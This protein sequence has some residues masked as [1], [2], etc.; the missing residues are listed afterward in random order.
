M[1]K[2]F[3]VFIMLFSVLGIAACGGNPSQIEISY[4]EQIAFPTNL[5]IDG[6]T[7]SWDAVE[8]AAGYYVY[9][10]GEEVKEVKTNSYDF[11]SLDGTRI[12]F[13]VVTKAPK[14]MQD[15]AQSASVAYVENK[16]EE[17]TAMQLVLSENL[18]MELDPG[19][20]EELVNKGMLATEFEDMMDA[21]MEFVEDMDDV[22]N[23]NEG[24]AAIDTMMESVENPEAIISAVVKYLLPDLLA[25]QIEMLEDDQAWYQAEINANRDYWGYY[26]ER[27]DEIDDEI[28]ALE[29]L[30]DMLE[31]SS[32]EVVKTVLFV[33]DYIMSIEEL[34]TEDL[35]TKIQNL[36]E[37][38][39]PEDLNV[40]ELVLVK[41]EIVNILRTTM[42]EST[43]V[44]LAINTLYSMTAI[45]EEMQEVQ[46]GEMGSPEKMAGTMLLSFEAFI[47]YVDNFDQ[48]FF[49]EL[50][51]IL[52]SDDH[53]YTQQAKVVTLVIE[54]FDNYLE[55]NEDLLDEI[56]NI[57]T[58]EEKEAMFNDYLETVED[59][60]SEE[61]LA[62]DLSF[63]NYDQL[64][65][66]NAI[67]DEAFNELLDAFVASDGALL[68]LIAEMEEYDYEFYS[69]DWED[70]DW[71]EHD[72][73]STIY[74]FKIMN[75]VVT[76][77]N[78]VVSE[79]T[80]EDFETVRGLIIDY[81]GFMVPLMMGNM[82]DVMSTETTMDFT[83]IIT[84]IETFME[85]TT[86]DQYGLIQNIFA[87][88]DEEDVFLDY[89]NAYETLYEDNFDD[90]HNEDNDYFLFAF[91]M[92]VYDGLV[93]NETRGY[94][95][96]IID[97][98]IVL[99]ENE[100]LADVGLEA[101]PDLVSEVLDYLDT[102]SGEVAGFDYTD[103]TTANKTRID[104]IMDELQDI[105]WDK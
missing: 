72:Y 43:D 34:I 54:Y 1:K 36:S 64:M 47:N 74:Q 95:D 97:A 44:I 89:A 71:N 82:M 16:E 84:D 87:Y 79:R 20:A 105:M 88:L 68:L 38:E 15:S 77:L 83:S 29:E 21:F 65:A 11:S 58:E 33:I 5:A 61:G 49:T 57:Y 25:E 7:L 22:D 9:A 69:Q 37:T 96:G 104:E 90:I 100:M 14:G 28:A 48:A 17:V 50:K 75:E 63:I 94:L 102:V 52:T 98:V 86:E 3:L 73:Y 35:I 6:K 27:V 101:Y 8:N 103:L 85:N 42:P 40:A 26:Q 62:L 66:V 67:F 60:I 12:I 59:A 70:M 31:D 10:D 76:L 23:M 19:F 4:D 99:L 13:T 30:Q 53:E 92:D 93:D 2:L 78:A 41:D 18:P 51:T 32:D 80:Q 45:L 56:D 46:F 39:G 91:L 81:V 55:E 24:F